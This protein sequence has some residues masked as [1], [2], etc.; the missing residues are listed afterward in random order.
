M[1]LRVP[2]AFVVTTECCRAYLSSD[3][4]LT[5]DFGASVQSATE[6]LEAAVGRRF[7]GRHPL[8][9]SVRSSPPVSMPG[10][11]DTVLNVGLNEPAVHGL[12]RNTGNPWLA[13]DAYR[14]FA[15]GYAETVLG[16]P[17]APFDR[18]VATHVQEAGVASLQ[19]LDPLAMR[20]LARATAALARALSGEPIP[21]DAGTQLEAAIAAVFRLV[22]LVT[23]PRIPA[24]DRPA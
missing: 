13:W 22:D 11:L 6:C 17:P 21:A 15:R 8:L 23:R 16:C 7:G 19:D 24:L 5:A 4:R 18:L 14:R 3:Q 20:E 12:V 2:P 10:M 9:V 1:G